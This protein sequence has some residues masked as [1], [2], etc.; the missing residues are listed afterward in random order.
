MSISQ[1][2]FVIR[3]TMLP[4]AM[5]A[6][7]FACQAPDGSG[8]SGGQGGGRQDIAGEG[9]GRD[10][11]GSAGQGSSARAGNAGQDGTLTG[12]KQSGGIAGTAAT[13]GAMVGGAG[14]AVTTG[15]VGGRGNGIPDAGIVDPPP[16]PAGAV[17]WTGKG[18]NV[19][20]ST[21][22][23]WSN[24]LVPG[25]QTDVLFDAT[26]AKACTI[27]APFLAKSIT[28]TA[29]H[30]RTLMFGAPGKIAGNL[31]LAGEVAILYNPH[32][33]VNVL[34]ATV[35]LS[36]LTVVR[37]GFAKGNFTFA[38]PNTIQ[39]LIPPSNPSVRLPELQ[40]IDGST[41][42]LAGPVNAFG[43]YVES[44]GTIDFAGK[45]LTVGLIGVNGPVLNIGGATVT[46]TGFANY[47][48]NGLGLSYHSGNSTKQLN[49]AP[50]TPWKLIVN[51]TEKFYGGSANTFTL[52][53]A[54]I[55]NLTYT[56][57]AVKITSCVNGGGNSGLAF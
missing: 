34:G 13:G 31:I 10:M 15:G 39:T 30:G 27:N 14:G 8:G 5:A 7:S 12:G 22:A 37:T 51:Q 11:G 40:V 47:T 6:L 56:G 3:I 49:L 21:P 53:N 48:T 41:M 2:H 4:L 50:T 26:A 45:N 36:G 24:N 35:D 43:L 57:D 29:N 33:H 38:G 19:F 46:V 25:L 32:D 17:V 42:R 54:K 18:N 20:W 16:V 55:A 28:V 9:G 23:N 52:N 1:T 44:T